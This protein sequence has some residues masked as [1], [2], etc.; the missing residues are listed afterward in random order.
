MKQEKPAV[1]RI[2]SSIDWKRIKSYHTKL[3][4]MWEYEVDGEHIQKVPTI[5]ELKGE[6]AS[7]LSHMI[8]QGLD[9]I[10]YG[11]WIIFWDNEG[12]E[13]NGVRVIFRLADFSF[14]ED[15]Q[16]RED[17]EDLLKKAIERED[18]EYAAV[19]RDEI[20]KEKHANNNIK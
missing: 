18:Y 9:Y 8:E 12:L 11:S 6:L 20:N 17:L 15:Q 10:S 7:I 13:S 4:I 16:N 1:S 19:I 3:G 2:V 14:E 5:A